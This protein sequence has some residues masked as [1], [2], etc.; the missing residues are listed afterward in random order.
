MFPKEKGRVN[1]T[2]IKGPIDGSN[3][4]WTNG[5]RNTHSPPPGGMQQSFIRGD[6]CHEIQ[7]LTLLYAI[8]DRKDTPFV[9][10]PL[11]NGTPF[12]SYLVYKFA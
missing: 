1:Q 9:F 3:K 12:A 7:P 8:F 5:D 2:K 10:L 4:S 11:T 6:S